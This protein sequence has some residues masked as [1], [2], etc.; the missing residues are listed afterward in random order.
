MK[1][2]YDKI[3]EAAVLMDKNQTGFC[4]HAL[5]AVDVFYQPFETI[6]IVDEFCDFY[7]K[8][9]EEDW[10]YNSL[11]SGHECDKIRVLLLLLFAEA[12]S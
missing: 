1:S 6:D 7:G 9:K 8:K 2:R 5:R 12:T 3:V 11:L 10:F 4:C